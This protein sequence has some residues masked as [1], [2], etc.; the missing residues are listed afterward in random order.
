MAPGALVPRPETE[1]LGYAVVEVLR[2]MDV[3]TARVV[4]MCC[5]AGNLACAIAH[6][7]PRTLVWAS[8]L[9]RSCAEVARRNV[10]FR[11]LSDRVAVA[12]GRPVRSAHSGPPREHYRSYRL[13]PSVHFREAARR[14]SRASAESGTAG[15]I[16]GWAVLPECSSPSD[17]RRARF[18]TPRRRFVTGGWTWPGSS[19]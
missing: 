11:E 3:A 1:L 19:S 15:G 4:D 9:T 10:I 6:H 2:S 18:F 12:S 5:G 14:R 7:A 8:D 16:R 17:Q 13:Q